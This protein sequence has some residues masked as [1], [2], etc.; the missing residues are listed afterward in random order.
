M[1]G[2]GATNHFVAIWSVQSASAF[3]LLSS[4]S[5]GIR[6]VTSVRLE[7]GGKILERVVS[8]L[9]NHNVVDFAFTGGVAVG[10]WAAPRQT[11]DIIH[12]MIKLRRDRRRLLQDLAD[13]RAVVDAQGA[14]LD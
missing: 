4:S 11:K 7:P 10:I 3:V 2:A 12:K 1:E 13:V 9:R 6:I 5:F 14:A 8:V